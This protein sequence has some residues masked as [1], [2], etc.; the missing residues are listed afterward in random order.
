M[1]Y[2][3]IS[4]VN[5]GKKCKILLSLCRCSTERDPM[6]LWSVA[7]VGGRGQKSTKNAGN[8]WVGFTSPTGCDTSRLSVSRD[9]PALGLGYFLQDWTENH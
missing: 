6:T 8:L 7:K 5:S 4:C 9:R 2:N 3:E 1:L